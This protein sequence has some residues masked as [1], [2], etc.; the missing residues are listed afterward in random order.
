M[1]TLPKFQ[2]DLERY[3]DTVL[4][5]KHNIRLYEESIE[6]LIRQIGC[7]DFENAKSLFDKLFDIRSE[8]AT[9]LYKYEYEPEKRIR[10]LIYNLDRN[11]F[12]SRMYWYEKF[13]DGFTWPE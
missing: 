9:M 11:D 7:S 5:I 13:I 4:S 2:R 12:Y 10:D 3:R 6:S 8:L 1:N